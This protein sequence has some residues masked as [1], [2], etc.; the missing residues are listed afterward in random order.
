MSTAVY[1]AEW[2]NR[3][4]TYS[5]QLRLTVCV[6]ASCLHILRMLLRCRRVRYSAARQTSKTPTVAYRIHCGSKPM[7][8][9]RPCW[10]CFGTVV[11]VTAEQARLFLC[12]TDSVWLS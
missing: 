8:S 1:A 4:V 3:K 7:R 12:C 10:S 9:G 5:A 11:Q 2:S 6:G